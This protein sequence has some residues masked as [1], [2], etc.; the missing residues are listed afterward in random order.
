MRS[1]ATASRVVGSALL[2][3]VVVFA[4]SLA[5][6]DDIPRLQLYAQALYFAVAAAG[7]NLLTGYN[8]QVSIGH[9]AFFGIGAFTSAILVKE[10]GWEFLP[11]MP[12]A[13]LFAAVV[14]VLVGFPALRVRGLYL[15]LVTLGLA[16]IF[17]DVIK[18]FF[19]E[20]GQGQVTVRSRLLRAPEWWPAGI[21]DRYQWAYVVTLIVTVGAFV[22]SAVVVRLR[23]G[24]ALVAVRDHEAAAAT[25]GINPAVVKLGAFGVSAAYAGVAGSLSVLVLGNAEANKATTFNQS[26]LFLIAVVVGGTAT[27]VGPLVGGWF[28]VMLQDQVNKFAESPDR[29]LGLPVPGPVEDFVRGKAVLTPAIFGILLVVSMYL[30]P[31]GIVGATRRG[32]NRAWGAA[33]KRRSTISDPARGGPDQQ[34]KEDPS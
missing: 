6:S 10:H 20:S 28:V 30:L 4:C 9:G 24:R 13:A 19:D 3:A 7:L 14:G 15:A 25:L 8:G 32:W 22:L 18:R 12:V 23:F 27:V 29:L 16:T 1:P 5:T 26:I 33:A 2:A 17:P 34:R 31:D 11:T 21:G